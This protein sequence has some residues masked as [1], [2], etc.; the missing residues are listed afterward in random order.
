MPIFFTVLTI[1]TILD[2]FDNDNDKTCGLWDID[3]NSDDWEPEFMT[4]FVT[5]QLRVTLE[6]M[7]K[8][9]FFFF[10]AEINVYFPEKPECSCLMRDSHLSKMSALQESM[11]ARHSATQLKGS[12]TATG[13]FLTRFTFWSDSPIDQIRFVCCQ[14]WDTSFAVVKTCLL[15][16]HA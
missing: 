13:G 9:N 11:L 8:L 2:D 5:W 14:S 15:F 12:G 16:S 1:L 7:F 10:S 4:I 6:S 3:K